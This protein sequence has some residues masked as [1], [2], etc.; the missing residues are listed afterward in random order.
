MSE[1]F[2]PARQEGTH[3]S[4]SLSTGRM[5]ELTLPN[6]R[7]LQTILST[8]EQFLPDALYNMRAGFNS[9]KSSC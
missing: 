9:P 5:N 8:Q 3:Q 4:S 7:G 6:S 1:P 2:L